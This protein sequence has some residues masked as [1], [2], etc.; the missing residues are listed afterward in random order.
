[1]VE[2]EKLGEICVV[3]SCY[4]FTGVKDKNLSLIFLALKKLIDSERYT[5][6]TREE[7]VTRRHELITLF[8]RKLKFNRWQ[9]SVKYPKSDLEHINMH[10]PIFTADFDPSLNFPPIITPLP[11]PQV[12]REWGLATLILRLKFDNMMKVLML[13]LLEKPLLLVGSR[14]DE[15][16][17]CS[18]TFL[19]LLAPYKWAS[20]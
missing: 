12:R 8:R 6:L 16:S 5:R 15:V 17:I 18:C 10:Y 9:F 2:N 19:H 4:I 1:M 20:V 11:L 13:L 7:K 14:I 3:E